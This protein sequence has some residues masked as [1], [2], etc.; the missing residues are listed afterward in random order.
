MMRAMCKLP[1]D[2]NV[3]FDASVAPK[4]EAAAEAGMAGVMREVCISRAGN[5]TCPVAAGAVFLGVI[6]Y[7]QLLGL[8][9]AEVTAALHRATQSEQQRRGLPRE[10]CHA[11]D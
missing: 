5:L 11:R 2:S 1:D 7:R 4:L 9:P 3:I 6:D 10:G 8:T